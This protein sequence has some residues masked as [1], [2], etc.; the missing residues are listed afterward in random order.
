MHFYSLT[1]TQWDTLLKTQYT[2]TK[3]KI[4]LLRRTDR[5][6][7]NLVISLAKQGTPW[8]EIPPEFGPFEYSYMKFQ[9]WARTSRWDHI[10][11]AVA[12]WDL[13]SH[14]LPPGFIFSVGYSV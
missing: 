4:P 11:H 8:T 7:V 1:N 5:R 14:S 13:S 9:R 10:F 2:C 6:F 12:Q 3:R